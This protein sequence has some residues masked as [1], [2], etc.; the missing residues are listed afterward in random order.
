MIGGAILIA[1]VAVALFIVV[2]VLLFVTMLFFKPGSREG[3]AVSHVTCSM[4]PTDETVLLELTTSTT[5][6]WTS[7]FMIEPLVTDDLSTEAIA[8]LPEGQSLA[9]LDV[10]ESAALQVLLDARE[11]WG[12]VPTNPSNVV[13]E[14]RRAN[15]NVTDVQLPYV[16]LWWTSG[17]PAFVQDIQIEL[18][19]TPTT[20]S[21]TK[22]LG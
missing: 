18:K 2:V 13:I 5:Q 7:S 4:G 8:T 20:C 21:V 15:Q 3:F 9:N 14:F 12:E 19:L 6:D 17:E 1:F 11:P 16:R 10:E 22:Y